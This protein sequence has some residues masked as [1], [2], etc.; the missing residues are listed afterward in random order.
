MKKY[1]VGLGVLIVLVS[2][3][4]LLVPSKDTPAPAD[5][6]DVAQ[7][8]EP[9]AI[10]ELVAPQAITP[11]DEAPRSPDEEALLEEMAAEARESLP[12]VVID[13]VTM[14]DAVFLPRMRIMEYRYV[15][16]A[17]EALASVR[18]VRGMIEDRAESICLEG[19]E[20]FSMDVTMRNSFEDR[21]GTIFQRVYILPEDCS[22]FY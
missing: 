9:G 19:R 21:D 11:Q 14:T 6:S 4:F 2:G 17:A 7:N 12:S 13:N 22:Q 10:A 20:M 5:S 8:A 1:L 15:T 18:D 16:T 3:Y